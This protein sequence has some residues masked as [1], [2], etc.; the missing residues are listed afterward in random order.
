MAVDRYTKTVLTVI[1]GCLVWLCAMGLP[2]RLDAQ[3]SLVRFDA[4]KT[5]AQPVI[6]VGTGTMDAAGAVQIIYTGQGPERHTNPTL[7]V[8]LP[9]NEANPM[10]TRLF[11]TAQTPLPVEIA[12]VKKAG[13]WEPLRVSVEDAPLRARPGGGR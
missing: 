10:P 3:Q 1:A 11:Y 5:V 13:A 12:S 9:F 7:P 2:A 8:A 4:M 6:V